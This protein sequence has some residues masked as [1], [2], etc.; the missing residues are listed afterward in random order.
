MSVDLPWP[1]WVTTLVAVGVAVTGVG[2]FVRSSSP[3]VRAVGAVLAVEG[4]LL[5]AVAPA[6]M[7]EEDMPATIAGAPRLTKEEFARRA[8]ANCRQL[9]EFAAAL[10]EPKTLTAT[11]AYFERLLP[12]ARKAYV[13]QGT[14]VPPEGLEDEAMRWMNAMALTQTQIDIARQAAERGDQAA[15]DEAFERT[16][17][18]AGAAGN[19]SREFGMK[20]CFASG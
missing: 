9:D 4:V 19:L 20:V 10:G 14:L 15:V 12:E 3:W 16:G 8:D 17:P 18:P 6:V 11:A 1:W 5:A 7:N 2:V 13:A